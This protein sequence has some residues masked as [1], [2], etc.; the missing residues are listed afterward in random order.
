MMSTPTGPKSRETSRRRHER[1][2]ARTG[3]RRR[4]RDRDR[5]A[6]QGRLRA[7]L[8]RR[9]HRADRRQG[10]VRERLEP[11]PRRPLG[12]GPAAGPGLQHPGPHRRHPRRR[13]GRD[14]DA[15]SRVRLPAGLRHH[16]RPGPRGPLPGRRD[17]AVVRRAGRARPPP[18]GRA[19][20]RGRQGQHA[21]GAVHDPLEGRGRPDARQG[22]RRLLELRRRARHERLD[23]HRSRH[24]LD[25]R[26]RRRG[27]LRCHR[28]DE[29]ARCT[30]AP[31]RGCSA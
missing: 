23:V 12:P 25:R 15:G 18:A 6:G 5:R 31:R 21:R 9:G 22:D 20:E 13:P 8:P 28:R 17:G 29:R 4:L 3:G 11:A 16:R 14:R 27:V 26:R 30:V 19:P 24:H 10:A 2:P 7:A 1:G